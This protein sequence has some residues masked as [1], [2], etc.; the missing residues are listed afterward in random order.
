MFDPAAS[1]ADLAAAAKYELVTRVLSFKSVRAT[2]SL[3]HV[4]D[5]LGLPPKSPLLRIERVRIIEG[6]P[7][8][9]EDLY[10]VKDRFTDL[11]RTDAKSSLV[12]LSE[13]HYKTPFGGI[14]Q[15][16]RAEAVDKDVAIALDLPRGAPIFGITVTAFAEAG[17]RLWHGK[18]CIRGDSYELNGR[19]AGPSG[20][21]PAIGRLLFDE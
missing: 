13:G 9:Y 3:D 1:L 21:R 18:V 16:I 10:L 8:A 11:S 20:S 2:R 7:I 14:D 19:I 5:A 4:R 12:G 6:Y 17:H 15:K